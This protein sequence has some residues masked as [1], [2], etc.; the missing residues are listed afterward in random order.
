MFKT[1]KGQ[2]IARLIST[3]VPLLSVLLSMKTLTIYYSLMVERTSTLFMKILV[4][5]LCLLILK[6]VDAWF[7]YLKMVSVSNHNSQRS[8]VLRATVLRR[9]QRQAQT[10]EWNDV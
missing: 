2:V 1:L 5:L 6:V 3:S 10:E 8:Q 7:I 4:A 9:D